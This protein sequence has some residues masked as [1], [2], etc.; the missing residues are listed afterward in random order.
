MPTS[1]VSARSFLE[2]FAGLMLVLA[3]HGAAL[4]GLW[5]ARLIPSPAEAATLLVHFI[6]P[7]APHAPRLPERQQRSTPP[8]P[9]QSKPAQ[10]VLA[11]TSVA[12]PPDWTVPE[13][14]TDPEPV[15]SPQ[16]VVAVPVVAPPQ[17]PVALAGELSVVCPQRTGPAYPALSLRLGE[18]G[19]VVLWVELSESGQVAQARV[20]ASS[21]YARLDQAALVAVRTWQCMPATRGGQPVRAT[22]LQPFKFVI[23]GN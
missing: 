7:P 19:V 21:G 23:Q 4:Y 13:P 15:P 17:G 2:R 14:P 10:R 20:H 12:A 22:A 11:A 9:V 8:K 3:L 1:V 6:T 5:S 16:T 18:A